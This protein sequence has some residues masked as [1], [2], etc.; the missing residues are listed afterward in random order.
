MTLIKSVI[1]IERHTEANA[2]GG[3][4]TECMRRLSRAKVQHIKQTQL[5]IN[6]IYYTHKHSCEYSVSSLTLLQLICILTGQSR[7]P[8]AVH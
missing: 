4:L 7:T 1:F 3:S 6:S 8:M 2:E 5:Y